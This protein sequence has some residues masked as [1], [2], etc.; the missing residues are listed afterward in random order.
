VFELARWMF[1]LHKALTC[2]GKHGD[3]VLNFRAVEKC[4]SQRRSVDVNF[5][6]DLQAIIGTFGD[7]RCLS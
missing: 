3:G 2:C 4:V 5:Q 6:C 1:C 7:K